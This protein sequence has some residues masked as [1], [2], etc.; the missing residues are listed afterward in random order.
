MEQGDIVSET[1]LMQAL[2]KAARQVAGKKALDVSNT[3]QLRD[4]CLAAARIFGWK[5]ESE[6]NVAVSNQVGVV[7]TDQQRA[8]MQAKLRELQAMSD[9]SEQQS[10]ALSTPQAQLRANAGA[11]NA[12][13]GAPTAAQTATSPSL[14]ALG[15]DLAMP[16]S[17]SLQ[18]FE[19]EPVC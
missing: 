11:G 1:G 7:I 9:D 14:S 8:E 6:V 16:E 10:P 17:Q 18:E 13:S 19:T 3:A 12:P 15:F 2:A 5:G 4:I